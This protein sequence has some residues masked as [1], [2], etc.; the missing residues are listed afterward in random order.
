[1]S[2]A[3]YVEWCKVKDG[4]IAELEAKRD[5]LQVRLR[6]A[7]RL[8]NEIASRAYHDG[9]IGV[10]FCRECDC[11]W[12][13]GHKLDCLVGKVQDFL[14]PTPPDAPAAPN[15]RWVSG[16]PDASGHWEVDEVP[17]TEAEYVTVRREHGVSMHD[18]WRRNKNKGTLF[19]D[20]SEAFECLKAALEESKIG[21][22]TKDKWVID[23]DTTGYGEPKS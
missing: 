18:F 6:A 17:A 19:A 3:F 23:K 1:M 13:Y 20:E 16:T 10:N 2:K 11:E 12:G 14:T 5:S 22:Q 9:T 8:L 15:E 21:A 7:E 4:E